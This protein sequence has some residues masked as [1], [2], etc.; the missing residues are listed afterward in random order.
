MRNG[1]S[2]SEKRATNFAPGG[3]AI[4]MKNARAAV[5]CLAGEGKFTAGTGEFGTP[6]DQLRY[7]LRAFFYEELNGLRIGQTVA[8]VQCVLLMQRD[9]I[10]VAERDSNAALCVRRG[11]FIQVGFCEDEYTASLAEFY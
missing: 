7:I 10:F 3:I 1:M 6:L 11:R 5:G 9:L 4:S 2:A 8:S